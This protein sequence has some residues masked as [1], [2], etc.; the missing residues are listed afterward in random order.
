MHGAL[1]VVLGQ[2]QEVEARRD[3][4]FAQRPRKNLD[5]CST[6]R[7]CTQPGGEEGEAPT[8]LSFLCFQMNP[9][10]CASARRSTPGRGASLNLATVLCDGFNVLR[11]SLLVF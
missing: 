2:K 1:I 9:R 6:R 11:G 3:H 4:A 5:S 7:G 8:A 10:S